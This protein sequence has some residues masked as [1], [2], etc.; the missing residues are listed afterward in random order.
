M[1]RNDEET[2][3]LY[4]SNLLSFNTSNNLNRE[5]TCTIEDDYH[6]AL[7]SICNIRLNQEEKESFY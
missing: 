4:K 6:H 2:E 1:A 7:P 5:E 3:R